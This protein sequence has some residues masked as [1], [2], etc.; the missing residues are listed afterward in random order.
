M[1]STSCGVHSLLED[2]SLVPSLGDNT[3]L[4]RPQERSRKRRASENESD[5]SAVP[6]TRRLESI[7]NQIE[8]PIR[9]D[10][11]EHRATF[12]EP[13]VQ[14]VPLEK[15]GR[16][17]GISSSVASTD[18]FWTNVWNQNEIRTITIRDPTQVAES[19]GSD[20]TA[21]SWSSSWTE[22]CLDPNCK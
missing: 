20:R 19:I 13:A 8:V 3:N 17:L 5:D 22:D 14:V 11:F 1:V 18:A 4:Q 15:P 9:E 6:K 21:D 2:G 16:A 12:F 7:L 10:C